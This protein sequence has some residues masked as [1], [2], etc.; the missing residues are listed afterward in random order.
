MVFATTGDMMHRRLLLVAL[1]LLIATTALAAVSYTWVSAGVTWTCSA[2]STA[3]LYKCVSPTGRVLYVTGDTETGCKPGDPTCK[4]TRTIREDQGTMCMEPIEVTTSTPG[5][6]TST[7]K[8][9]VDGDPSQLF[10]LVPC[11]DPVSAKA[12]EDP[13][14][15]AGRGS[16]DTGGGYDTGGS[17]DPGTPDAAGA[18]DEAAAPLDPGAASDTGAAGD[19]GAPADTG[20]PSE[21]G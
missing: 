7:V 11:D 21:A 4:E 5:Q 13:P 8:S 2:T 14:K 6:I 18:P 15:E 9:G 17:Y 12:D 19:T 1:P 20:S 3:R 10:V 16:Y